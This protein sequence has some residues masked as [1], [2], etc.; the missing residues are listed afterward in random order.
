MDIEA[1]VD[2]MTVAQCRT[3]L[4]ALLSAYCRPAFGA[5]PKREIDILLFDLLFDTGLVAPS[6]SI[7]DL[8]RDLRIPRTKARTLL[9]D[10]EVRLAENGESALDARLRSLLGSAKFVRDGSY[11]VLEV[12]SPLVQ[13]HMR[14]R[15]RELGHLTDSSFNPQLV[16]LQP[17]AVTALAEKIIPKAERDIIRKALVKAGAP[18]RS[19]KGVLRGAFQV[20]GQH[21][22]KE[23]GSRAAKELFD[24]TDTFLEPVFDAAGTRITA[25]WGAIFKAAQSA[26]PSSESLQV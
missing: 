20:L 4:K 5:L 16:R 7:Y 19:F 8:M 15:L 18:D 14:E 12:E 22:A 13:A 10:R 24:Q 2:K 17:G 23:A 6:A 11:F 3:V 25:A 26:A 9:Y 21:I 1:S